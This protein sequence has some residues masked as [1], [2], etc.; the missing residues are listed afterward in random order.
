MHWN[1][2][3]HLINYDGAQSDDTWTNSRPLPLWTSSTSMIGSFAIQLH[4]NVRTVSRTHSRHLFHTPARVT[5]NAATATHL[6]QRQ[7]PTQP[8]ISVFHRRRLR[9]QR[10]QFMLP[11]YRPC[12]RL[13]PLLHDP[14]ICIVNNLKILCLRCR[15]RTQ[16]LGGV[17][18]LQAQGRSQSQTSA[19]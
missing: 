2:F 7:H 19:M 1:V 12:R 9:P 6:H 10:H 17:Q 18:T 8:W 3:H 11:M 13:E 14:A 16:D 5:D 15:Y 4:G